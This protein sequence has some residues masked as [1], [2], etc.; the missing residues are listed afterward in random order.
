MKH[1][2]GK[3]A[4]ITGAAS[5]IGRE[6][7]AACAAQ[8]M[9]LVLADV[10]RDGLSAT[11]DPMPGGI[12]VHTAQ[13][14]VSSVEAVQRLADLAFEEFGN[15]HL[16]FNNAG[17]AALGPVW[18]ATPEDWTW[19]LGVNLLGVVN[20][21]RSF[22]PRMMAAGDEGHI[23]NTASAAGL[24][25]V[26]G[27]GAYCA[28]KHAVVALSECLLKDLQLAGSPL[29]VNVLCPSLVKTAIADSGRH[30]PAHLASTNPDTAAYD[31]RVRAGME[32]SEVSAADVAS[33]TIQAIHDDEF[34]ILP[35]PAV[36]LRV[37]E[38]LRNIIGD[39]HHHQP[40]GLL[41]STD[42]P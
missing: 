6:L 4:V 38:R 17:V 11:K 16:L 41:G 20:G 19:V 39:Q 21:I 7:A 8:G 31:Q 40:D 10:D 25:A 29:K 36:R 35:H 13:C 34:Y 27:S 42:E 30:R 18:S 23:V 1:L 3:V 37:E 33:M 12:A 9:K 14:D 26:A 28:S 5:G 2:E 32:E 24:T 22:V 15:V